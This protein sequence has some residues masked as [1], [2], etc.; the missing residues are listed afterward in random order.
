VNINDEAWLCCPAPAKL[1]LFLHITGQLPN[2]YHTLQTI[3]QFITL[4]DELALRARTDGQLLLHCLDWTLPASGNLVIKA[5]QALQQAG[6]VKLGAEI[7]LDKKIPMGGGLGGGS[8]DAA[9]TLLALNHLWELH[10]PLPRLAELGAALGADVPV[11]IHGQAAWAEGVGDQLRFLPDLAEPWYVLVHP[12][13]HAATA[14][15]YRA[16]DLTRN[17]P[18]V[19]IADF[20]VGQCCNDFQP[21]VSAW[22]PAVQAV[23]NTLGKYGTARLTGS[24]ACVFVAQASQREAEQLAARLAERWPVWA[25]QGR[26]QSPA[27]E[28]LA[29]RAR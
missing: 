15:L 21:V 16:A 29:L 9:T 27:H 25:V 1:N 17:H 22:F 20:L 7:R 10:W 8:S 12:G 26:N 13:C 23:L 3:F 6:A 14:E 2:G 18:S 28:F 5:A 19:T 4:Q 24:G 11:F